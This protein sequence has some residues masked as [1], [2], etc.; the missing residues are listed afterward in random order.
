MRFYRCWIAKGDGSCAL[1]GVALGLDINKQTHSSI[2]TR[3][4]PADENQA[5]DFLRLVT[6]ENTETYKNRM[7]FDCSKTYKAVSMKK[8]CHASTQS[9]CNAK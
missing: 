9:I 4:T 2:L 8:R 3:L 5:V 6:V 1:R 7:M